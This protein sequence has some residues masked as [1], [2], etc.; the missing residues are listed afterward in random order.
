MQI[1]SGLQCCPTDTERLEFT[2]PSE[3]ENAKTSRSDLIGYP[4]C[5]TFRFA[6]SK[7]FSHQNAKVGKYI[8]KLNL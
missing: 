5:M 4:K 8:K 3:F 6:Y 2:T 7:H 1:Y